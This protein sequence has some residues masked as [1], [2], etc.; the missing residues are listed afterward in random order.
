MQALV[1]ISLGFSLAHLLSRNLYDDELDSFKLILL[2]VD[3]LWSSANG[4]DIHPPGMYILSKLAFWVSGSERWMTILPLTFLYSGVVTFVSSMSREFRDGTALMTFFVTSLLHPQLLMWGNSIR[5]YPYWTG[6]ALVVFVLMLR[7]P[8]DGGRGHG[9]ECPPGITRS[10]LVGCLVAVMFY[11]NY[12]TVFY[13]AALSL[14]AMVKYGPTRRTVV[15]L[16]IVWAMM[17]LLGAFQFAPM[18][19]VHIANRPP[20]AP[21]VLA[22]LR[23][24]HGTLI[25]E[26]ILPWHPVAP[27]FLTLVIVPSAAMTIW[28][29]AR[30]LILQAT[31]VERRADSIETAVFV[32]FASVGI[33]GIMTGIGIKPRSLMFMAPL[34]SFLFARGM[35]RIPS[36][37]F[38]G[39]AL[40]VC[41][42][43]VV[44][45]CGNLL[46]KEG[47]AKGAMNQHPDDIV[48]LV[49]TESTDKCSVVFVHDPGLA[50]TLNAKKAGQHWS[51]CSF[52][53]DYVHG[54][55]AGVVSDSC[56]PEQV[57][58]VRTFI[59]SLLFRQSAVN[60]ALAGAEAAISEP[61]VSYLR[62]DRDARAKR[63]IPGLGSIAQQLPD[64]Q[65]VVTYGAA[66]PRTDWESITARFR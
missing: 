53:P 46:L 49:G 38:R 18:L 57:F 5:W 21:M 28:A 24:A 42:T 6:L 65:Y 1:L 45:S 58:V 48:A 4:N 13:L 62:F 26:A 7:P 52:Y 35:Q 60:A 14:A 66:D 15:R 40:A 51:V 61:R 37:T 20:A 19:F 36:H 31:L 55:P 59:G 41:C 16:G 32:L 10:I 12:I 2:P 22:A 8:R 3:A 64:Y 17:A 29:T 43:W 47:T 30:R 27:L 39:I 34:G 9:T 50:Y 63:G 25:S 54:I 56:R 11:I 33:I 44:A 23:L